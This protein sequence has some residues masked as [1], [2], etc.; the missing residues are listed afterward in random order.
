MLNLNV[1]GLWREP[2]LRLNTR[3]F[4]CFILPI[5]FFTPANKTAGGSDLLQLLQ[6][7]NY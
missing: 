3:V 4:S 2:R 6:V 5:F 7:G 1:N